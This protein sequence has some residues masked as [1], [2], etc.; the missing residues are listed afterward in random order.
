MYDNIDD[1]ILVR[2]NMVKIPKMQPDIHW[3]KW[4]DPYEVDLVND[5]E[6]QENNDDEGWKDHPQEVQVAGKYIFTPM[7]YVAVSDAMTLTKRFN[8]WMGHTNYELN[9]FNVQLLE[10]INGV[11]TL[12]IWTKYRFRVGIGKLFKDGTVMYQMK[13]VFRN[14]WIQQNEAERL[15][16]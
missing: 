7:G 12:D 16:T 3:E 8:F 11:E 9:N 1:A 5:Q 10:N 4:A 13:Q 2:N 6:T 14:F 15:T